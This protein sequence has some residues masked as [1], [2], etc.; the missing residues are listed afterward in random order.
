MKPK[1]RHLRSIAIASSALLA[2]SY[3]HAADLS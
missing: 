3:T 1:F 2:I